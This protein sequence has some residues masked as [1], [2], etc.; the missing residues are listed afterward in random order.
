MLLDKSKV[1]VILFCLLSLLFGKQLNSKD[2]NFKGLLHNW[3]SYTNEGTGFN[4][5]RVRLKA[6][7]KLD[8]KI[9]WYAQY[10]W[11]KQIAS[12]LDAAIS[13]K[14][15][16]YLSLKV[17][18]FVAP[19]SK[20]GA[21][22]SASKLTFVER[23]MVVKKWGGYNGYS[24]YRS[25]GLQAAGKF[26][27][28]R[29]STMLSNNSANALYNP[30]ITQDNYS[31]S[32]HLR[33][34]TRL[35]YAFDN[36]QVGVYLSTPIQEDKLG[37]SYGADLIYN[38]NSMKIGLGVIQGYNDNF[39]SSDNEYSGLLAHLA[40]LVGKIEPLLR[41]DMY[42]PSTDNLAEAPVKIYHNIT[43]GINYY[44]SEN[45]KIQVNYMQREEEMRSN[46]DK[47]DNNL[48]YVNLQYTF[49][50]QL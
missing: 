40:D 30:G 1:K 34:S 7:G 3:Y 20:Y 12:L 19:G 45:M 18:Q 29:Y 21:L 44:Y 26:N 48:F 14:F 31:D 15:N 43:G 47:L 37:R 50:S 17:G 27:N 39:D 13:Y 9:S 22:T 41:Y 4:I 49:D 5:R 25:V 42:N 33:F 46:L 2:L 6:Y 11:D 32:E 28:L 24:S 35:E 23:A 8:E 10:R 38:N 36:V 16:Q